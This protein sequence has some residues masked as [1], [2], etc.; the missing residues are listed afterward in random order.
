MHLLELKELHRKTPEEFVS[1]GDFSWHHS[2]ST[3]LGKGAFGEVFLGYSGQ[4]S[5]QVAVKI[6]KEDF[7]TKER[8]VY[9]NLKR[10]IKIMEVFSFQMWHCM[11]RCV[12]LIHLAILSAS[13]F[14]GKFRRVGCILSFP[15]RSW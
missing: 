15:F 10:E 5:Y 14:A 6:V 1:S 12:E 8:K 9:I 4:D 7:Y 11:C 2:S 3:R 13:V